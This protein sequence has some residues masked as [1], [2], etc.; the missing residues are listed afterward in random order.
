MLFRSGGGGGVGVFFVATWSSVRHSED[1]HPHGAAGDHFTGVSTNRRFIGPQ[2]PNVEATAAGVEASVVMC[3][4]RDGRRKLPLTV[5]AACSNDVR[6]MQQDF[7]GPVP[8]LVATD[9]LDAAIAYVNGAFIEP[10]ALDP[11]AAR[12]WRAQP[13]SRC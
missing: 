9:S 8:P 6:V 11:V 2:Q 1:A 13:K 12:A 5:L 10:D 3:P 7:F 4:A